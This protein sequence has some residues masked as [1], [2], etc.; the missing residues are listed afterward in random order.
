ML[1]KELVVE[2]FFLLPDVRDFLSLARVSKAWNHA[3]SDEIVW[4]RIHQ[5]VY[6]HIK[7]LPEGQKKWRDFFLSNYLNYSGTFEHSTYGGKDKLTITQ[8]LNNPRQ[9]TFELLLYHKII[10]YTFSFHKER[11]FFGV[12]ETNSFFTSGTQFIP[13]QFK[14]KAT[15]TTTTSW[16][17][18][19]AKAFPRGKNADP[20][21][22]EKEFPFVIDLRLDNNKSNCLVADWHLL[23]KYPD[24]ENNWTSTYNHENVKKTKGSAVRQSQTE[25]PGMGQKQSEEDEAE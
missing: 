8:N 4:E 2:L 24:T 6:P 7:T 15:K 13:R 3:V 18:H 17:T 12:L 20:E 11:T 23:E 22:L 1:P 25:N 16:S 14:G 9:A 21:V 19:N 10:D 5:R